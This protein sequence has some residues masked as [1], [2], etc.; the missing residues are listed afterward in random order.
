MSSDPKRQRWL[1][2]TVSNGPALRRPG[3]AAG[4]RPAPAPP[5]ENEQPGDEAPVGNFHISSSFP[6][7]MLTLCKIYAAV[8]N[9]W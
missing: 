1:W 5:A 7:L 6:R 9:L 3:A 2:T 4:A 8:E